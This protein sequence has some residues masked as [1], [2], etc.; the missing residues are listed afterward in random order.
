MNKRRTHPEL[1][2]GR[3][4]KSNYFEGWYYK[5]VSTDSS[6]TIALIPGISKND[7]DPH[8][9]IQVFISSNKPKETLQTYYLRFKLEEFSYQDDPFMIQIAETKFAL[10]HLT[11]DLSNLDFHL[12]GELKLSNLTPLKSTLFM[13]NIMGP[14]SYIPKMECSHG[15]VSMTHNLHGVLKYNNQEILFDQ[16]KG[17]IEKDWGS[18]FPKEYVWMQS[19]HFQNP[20]TSFMFSYASIPFLKHEFDGLICI[21]YYQNKEYRFSTYQR[22]KVQ[23]EQLKEHQAYYKIKQGKYTLEIFG[24]ANK[25]V[26]LKSPS[27]GQM[28]NQIKEGL[29]GKITIKFYQ[30]KEL[31]FEDTG[32]NAGIEIMKK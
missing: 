23:E 27:K 8:A 11:I 14:F 20:Q 24:E 32:T 10:D 22:V 18:S 16:A 4:K 21:L 26:L 1:F 6:S 28:I 17:Y 31:L 13:P 5:L 7:D 9:F 19:N 12:E 15:V 2:Q 3:K 25:G 30:N 29:S